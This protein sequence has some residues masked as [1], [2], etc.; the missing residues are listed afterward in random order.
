VIGFLARV[1]GFL[2]RVIGFLARG[3]GFLELPFPGPRRA[4]QGGLH[5]AVLENRYHRGAGTNI[6][7]EKQFVRALG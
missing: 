3:G 7:H 4:H 1:I 6:V 2:A 5:K